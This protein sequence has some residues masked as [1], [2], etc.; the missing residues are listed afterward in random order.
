MPLEEVY[1]SQLMNLP[2]MHTD[3]EDLLERTT[4]GFGMVGVK[5]DALLT[6]MAGI[7]DQ[8]TSVISAIS[9]T[10]SR[11]N[12]VN[13]HLVDNNTYQA[14]N[15]T[16]LYD[17]KVDSAETNSKLNDVITKLATLDTIY[18]KLYDT[19]VDVHS[20][21]G[22]IYDVWVISDSAVRCRNL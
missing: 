1:L 22:I 13:A 2:Y 4:S 14:N 8:L 5:F 7:S 19:G 21:Q 6:R 12:T 3:L 18:D 9:T 20:M 11:L 10:N 15:N 16:Y 17:I